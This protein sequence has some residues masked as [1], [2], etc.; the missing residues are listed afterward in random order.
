M[1]RLPASDP[2][3]S[4]RRARPLRSLALSPGYV[5]RAPPDGDGLPVPAG[6]FL[7]AATA[8]DKGLC[9]DHPAC[10]AS[11]PI[12]AGAICLDHGTRSCGRG[13]LVL[14]STNVGGQSAL[15]RA[16]PGNLAGP[17]GPMAPLSPRAPAREVAFIAHDS[18]LPDAS[19]DCPG[20]RLLA[21]SA[22]VLHPLIIG[23]ASTEDG[24]TNFIDV[25]N[26]RFFNDSR[27]AGLIPQIIPPLT[28][29]TLTPA[30][31]PGVPATSITFAP[32]DT[33]SPSTTFPGWMNAG[34]TR[35]AQWR[36]V[37]H[38]VMPGLESLSGD[39]SRAA[40]S[41]T[42]GLRLPPGKSLAPW[43]TAP[44]LR[45]GAPTPCALHSPNCVG[46]F[47]RFVSYSRTCTGLGNVLAN[48]DVPIV[49]IDGDG[50]GMQL[51]AVPGFDPAPECFSPN[52]LAGTVEVH[53]G[54]T[55]AGPWT[56]FEGLDALGRMP[57]GAQLVITGPR[58]D[59]PLDPS[60]PP[61]AR[62][63]VVSFTLSGP[64]PT[65]AGTFFSFTV[66][67]GQGITAVRDSSTAGQPGFA[68]PMVVYASARRPDPVVFTA[69]TGSNS[70]LI[71][72][73]AQFGL[74]NS[75]FFIY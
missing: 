21:S 40:G 39:L 43:T 3:D 54:A 36:A 38:G 29:L 30:P 58:I 59:Y 24:T 4:P 48:T 22:L 23:L 5:N 53:A 52:D 55:T 17:G 1:R 64:E 12:P 19:Q 74:S 73:P 69:L 67:D 56:V 7:L 37:W 57:H 16:P 72:V 28:S 2:G 46:D 20:L 42:V 60:S 32:A 71:A 47:V 35:S 75:L 61:P 6:T 15:L 27:D 9:T 26:R 51:L 50:L 41:P 34:V 62:D 13:R 33:T 25:L 18:C 8:E 63:I 31:P 10:P 14:L 70:L 66:S 45:L 11:L 49:A 68:G 44:E 65:V